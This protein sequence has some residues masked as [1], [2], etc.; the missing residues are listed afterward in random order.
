MAAERK[1]YPRGEWA[2]S[3]R[4]KQ[5]Q[6]QKENRMKCAADVPREVGETFRAWCKAQ[7]KTVSAVLADY[8]YS[9]VGQPEKTGSTENQTGADAENQTENQDGSAGR[10]L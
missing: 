10:E 2:E 4:K 3:T 1:P 7:N 6:W 5:V 9:I 8:I